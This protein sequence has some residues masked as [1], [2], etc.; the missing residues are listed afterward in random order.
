MESLQ[1]RDSDVEEL[2]KLINQ[3]FDY[4]ILEPA[5][6]LNAARPS[7]PEWFEN[8][9]SY[10]WEMTTETTIF[11]QQE[12][13]WVESAKLLIPIRNADI[14]L[15]IYPV[16]GL[17]YFVPVT[18]RNN[19]G[20]PKFEEVTF[21]ISRPVTKIEL[22]NNDHSVPFIKVRFIKIE[23]IGINKLQDAMNQ[24]KVLLNKINGDVEA[25]QS[26]LNSKIRNLKSTFQELNQ[27]KSTLQG[28][29][30]SL[31]L[32]EEQ[33][34]QKLNSIEDQINQQEKYFENVTKRLRKS[35]EEL[36]ELQSRYLDTQKKRDEIEAEKESIASE[37]IQLN[38]DSL[39]VQKVVTKYKKNAALYSEDF[40]TVKTSVLQQ[41]LFY[42]VALALICTLG[43]WIISNVYEGAMMLSLV[44][45]EKSLSAKAIWPLLISRL[46]L[47]TVNFLLL[48]AVSSLVIY[49]IKIIVKNNEE[50]KT[51]KQA[52]YLVRELI[53]YQSAGLSISEKQ[54]FEQRVNAKLKLIHQLLRPEHIYD[55]KS[56]SE[57]KEKTTS[58]D[59][60]VEAL[61]SVLK[62]QTSVK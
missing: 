2:T 49:L 57:T 4:A 34:Q 26:E 21:V 6:N 19:S 53:T 54:V 51:I 38:K 27:E 58:K 23:G 14:K 50:I 24:G 20:K 17:P 56:A 37:V 11:D 15:K 42:G 46:P 41:N 22:V 1:Q 31:K 25:I 43:W 45:D 10:L 55:E 36:T 7:S 30:D 60:I 13:S 32:A 62:K 8:E 28:D 29:L 12:A 33:A 47:I 61:E 35:N 39:E 48:T 40:S 59:T 5:K 18:N 3:L 52:A 16:S 9:K 44:I